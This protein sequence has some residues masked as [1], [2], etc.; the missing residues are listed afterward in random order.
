M[1]VTTACKES[2]YAWYDLVRLTG[3]EGARWVDEYSRLNPQMAQIM[4]AVGVLRRGELDTG[5]AMLAEAWGGVCAAE[6]ADLSILDVAERWYLGA[7]GYAHYCRGQL[8]HADRLM[9]RGGEALAR[10]IHHRP[11]LLGIADEAVELVMHRARIARN[12]RRWGEMHAHIDR[13][14][15]M[16]RGTVP[17]VVMPDGTAVC[18]FAVQRWLED[19]PLPADAQ[20]V[21]PHLQQDDSARQSTERFVRDVLRL[22]G[23]VIQHP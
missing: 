3:G 8:D 22:P 20:P 13:A 7:L 12:G 9:A 11:F 5:E 4:A 1:D 19:L 15:G 2:P 17:F 16:R 6:V 14:W 23:F 10:A 21:R 18:L